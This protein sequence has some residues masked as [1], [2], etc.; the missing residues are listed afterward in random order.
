LRL[1]PGRQNEKLS[2]F[3]RA[4]GGAFPIRRWRE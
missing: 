3:V 4:M 2:T 1:A